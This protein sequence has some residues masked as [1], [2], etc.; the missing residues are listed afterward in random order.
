MSACVAAWILSSSP[1]GATTL[2]PWAGEQADRTG[3]T[4]T[5]FTACS[6][7]QPPLVGY[8]HR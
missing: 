1:R 8:V 2:E 4:F 3:L 7:E 5:A 6:P